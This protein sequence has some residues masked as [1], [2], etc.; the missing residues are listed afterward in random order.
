VEALLLDDLRSLAGRLHASVATTVPCDLGMEAVLVECGM[1]PPLGVLAVPLDSMRCGTLQRKCVVL[2]DLFLLVELGG[3]GA[4]QGAGVRLVFVWRGIKGCLWWPVGSLCMAVLEE[5]QEVWGAGDSKGLPRAPPH[6]LDAFS[7]AGKG[8]L[9]VSAACPHGHSGDHVSEDMS[10]DSGVSIGSGAGGGGGG[11]S[12]SGSDGGGGGGGG[13]D[14]GPAAPTPLSAAATVV[15]SNVL[16]FSEL[17]CVLM[18]RSPL[19]SVTVWLPVQGS[20]VA[21]DWLGPLAWRLGGL[22]TAASVSINANVVDPVL[23]KPFLGIL[24]SLVAV[25]RECG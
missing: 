14:G 7:T 12:G 17:P 16:T 21:K 9:L 4:R 3:Q 8:C 1:P 20:E 11:G 25:Y 5:T 15:Q 24:T 2:G 19:D 23:L 22:G 13:G 10:G 6:P 18:E